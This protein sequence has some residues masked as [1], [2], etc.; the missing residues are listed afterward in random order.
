[1]SNY[2]GYN[3]VGRENRRVAREIGH[4]VIRNSVFISYFFQWLFRSLKRSEAYENKTEDSISELCQFLTVVTIL[5]SSRLRTLAAINIRDPS[6]WREN[7]ST[8]AILVDG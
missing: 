6:K 4:G 1:M 3:Y 7:F 5:G 8:A 2:I